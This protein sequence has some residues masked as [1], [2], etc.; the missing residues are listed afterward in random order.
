[1]RIPLLLLAS[2]ALVRAQDDN[3][4]ETSAAGPA[5]SSGT[6]TSSAECTFCTVPPGYTAEEWEAPLH[7]EDQFPPK[8]REAHAKAKAYLKDWT[9][10]EKVH[11]TT[12]SGWM[13]GR[14]V[15]NI[16]AVPE[17]N[18]TGLCLEDSPLGVRFA[19]YVSA[20]PAGINAAST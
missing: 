12:G 14:C 10:E 3:E 7:V 6:A 9:L 1:M 15:G 4:T 20:F 11:L 5:A 13:Q 8:W 17:R 2:L 16:P 19:D 18:W